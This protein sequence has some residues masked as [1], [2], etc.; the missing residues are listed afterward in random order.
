MKLFW[1]ALLAIISVPTCGVG[2][3]GSRQPLNVD[4]IAPGPRS[5][6]CS[7]NSDP[8]YDR[9]AVLAQLAE[10][11]NRSVW[12]ANANDYVFAVK[13]DRPERFTVYDLTEPP[14]HGLPLGPCVN[15]LDHHVY[16]FS[17]IQKRYSFSHIVVLEQGNLKV[18]R[19]LNCPGRGESLEDVIEYVR[20]KLEHDRN[21]SEILNRIRDYRTYG[22]YTTVDTP[23]L[24]CGTTRR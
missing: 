18:F 19:S 2:Q 10:T 23:T 13:A 1:Y 7:P 22:I 11:L 9:A 14:N 3:V 16:H 6:K 15:F 17:P 24:Q 5:E 21:N 20:P 8:L 4:F 12:G